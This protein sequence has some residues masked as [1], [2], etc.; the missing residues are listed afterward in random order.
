M[1]T[2]QNIELV[3]L[4]LPT[5][6]R[7]IETRTPESLGVPAAGNLLIGALSAVA[8][9][10]PWVEYSTV[11]N[12]FSLANVSSEFAQAKMILAGLVVVLAIIAGAVSLARPIAGFA[13]S[14]AISA[15]TWWATAASILG[16]I[17]VSFDD[18]LATGFHS[19]SPGFGLVM[20]GFLSLLGGATSLVGIYRAVRQ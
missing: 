2:L 5:A 15:T 14:L 4:P 20:I 9:F 18:D 13:L 10:L 7:G 8:C 6:H 16:V 19:V 17:S 12:D 1:H 11:L 3:E